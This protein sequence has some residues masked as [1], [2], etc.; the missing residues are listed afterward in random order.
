MSQA[1]ID[2]PVIK[3]KLFS[4]Q[5]DDSDTQLHI[6]LSYDYL[7]SRNFYLL[8]KGVNELYEFVFEIIH[9][10][11]ITD[12]EL[13]VLDEIH[14]GNSIDVVFKI[15]DKVKP[16]KSVWI[17]LAAVAAL[18]Y[19]HSHFLNAKKTSSETEYTNA[20]TVKIIADTELTKAQTE[21]TKAETERIKYE[22]ERLQLDDSL[23]KQ[24]IDKAYRDKILT[25]E[26]L[27]KINRKLNSIQNQ[28]SADPIHRVI[29]NGNVIYNDNSIDIK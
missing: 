26:N 27:K 29:V 6:Y 22:N 16:P 8:S 7:P 4:P 19:G 11:P 17:G 13:L 10:R 28:I 20:Q 25:T 21:K 24:E 12:A 9:S 3:N 5:Q 1:T 18:I 14:T 2:P 23:K 15:I